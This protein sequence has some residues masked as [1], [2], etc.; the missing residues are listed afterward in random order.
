M[1]TV[2][3]TPDSLPSKR[4]HVHQNLHVH[5]ISPLPAYGADLMQTVFSLCRVERSQKRSEVISTKDL[6]QDLEG[7]WKAIPWTL[8]FCLTDKVRIWVQHGTAT[9]LTTRTCGK[10][11]RIR[12]RTGGEKIG[13][14]RRREGHRGLLL[15]SGW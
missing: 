3:N 6:R 9:S 10:K 15:S 1:N 7:L 8:R 14:F 13:E 5:A 11:N 4:Y 2:M 12:G